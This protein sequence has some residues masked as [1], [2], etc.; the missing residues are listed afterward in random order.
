ME[1]MVHG[2]ISKGLETVVFTEHYE[3]LST[4]EPTGSF[5]DPGN[6]ERIADEVMR[7]RDAYAGRIRIGF[8][9]EIGQWQFAHDKVE[10]L[11]CSFP[12]DFVIASYHKVDDVDLKLHDYRREDVEALVQKYLCGLLEISAG[13]DFDSLAHLDLIRRYAHMQGVDVH[14]ETHEEAVR[15]VL[16]N[17]VRRGRL[18]EVNTSA[19]RQ[20]LDEPFPSATILRWYRQEGGR[21]VSLGSDAH[22]TDDIAAGFERATTLVEALG[23]EVVTDPMGKAHR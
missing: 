18:L 7:L 19:Y 16:S 11:L 21:L 6:V 4:G 14:I 20:G 15:A 9:L 10:R 13:C 17:I 1:D 22:R 3:Y 23:L 5:S 12:F 8:G 2:A